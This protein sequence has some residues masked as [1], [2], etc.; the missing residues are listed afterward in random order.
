MSTADSIFFRKHLFEIAGY[1][2]DIVS[3]LDHP[4]ASPPIRLMDGHN[5]V[6]NLCKHGIYPLIIVWDVNLPDISHYRYD[7]A[8]DSGVYSSRDKSF[9]IFKQ[10]CLYPLQ[11]PCKIPFDKLRSF[12]ELIAK[13]DVN[14]SLYGTLSRREELLKN[15]DVLSEIYAGVISTSLNG[16][17]FYIEIIKQL[18]ELLGFSQ[19]AD[20][21]VKHSQSFFQSW[22]VR[23]WIPFCIDATADKM[24]GLSQLFS[25]GV[26]TPPYFRELVCTQ[27]SRLSDPVFI[28]K[29]LSD[30]VKKLKSGEILPSYEIFFWTMFLAGIRHFGNDYGFFSKLNTVLYDNNICQFSGKLQLSEHNKDSENIVQ[31]DVGRSFNCY[32]SADDC[33]EIKQNNPTLG[34]RSASITSLYCCLGNDLG[35]I[36]EKIF[37][38]RMPS[39]YIIKTLKKQ[40]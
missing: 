28:V 31:F 33:Y 8:F 14:S 39:P 17:Q 9:F 19:L 27:D 1:Q 11:K 29:N 26:F 25:T 21:V 15:F 3:T 38:K 12:I 10:D 13:I 2:F 23:E 24:I 40:N 18:Y 22:I 37:N 34:R 16:T 35:K 7:L 32:K 5:N 6:R 30:I 36:I 4:F 20:F